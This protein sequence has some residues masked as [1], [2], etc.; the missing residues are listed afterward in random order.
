MATQ[1]P[2]LQQQEIVSTTDTASASKAK[3][4][5][6]SADAI[7]LPSTNCDN[8]TSSIQKLRFIP[9]KN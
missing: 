5:I 3:P 9:D 2:T 7:I 6:A 4:F 1:N 8:I